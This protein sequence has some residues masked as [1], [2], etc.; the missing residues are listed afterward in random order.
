MFKIGV[1]TGGAEELF[2]IDG[3]YRVIKEAHVPTPFSVLQMAE[4]IEAK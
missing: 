2:G 3:A 1:Q 4:A